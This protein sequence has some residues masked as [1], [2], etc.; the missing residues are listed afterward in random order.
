MTLRAILVG[1]HV[2]S[3]SSHDG[4]VSRVEAR[5]KAAAGPPGR[6]LGVG[7][8]TQ[9]SNPVKHIPVTTT[10]QT[11]QITHLTEDRQCPSKRDYDSYQ[12]K[13]QAGRSKHLLAPQKHITVGTWNTQ[14][15]PSIK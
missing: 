15:S 8:T 6:G 1:A 7:L 9:L 2:P 11:N 10:L 4:Q 13:V 12:Q 3:R 14:H 5:R